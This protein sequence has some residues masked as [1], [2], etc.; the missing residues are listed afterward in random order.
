[1]AIGKHVDDLGNGD[2]SAFY[3]RLNMHSGESREQ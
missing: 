2:T 3:G 1:V